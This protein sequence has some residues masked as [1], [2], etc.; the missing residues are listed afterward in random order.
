VTAE[1]DGKLQSFRAKRGVIVATGGFALNRDMVAQHAP[2]YLGCDPVDVSANDGWGIRAGESVG[3]ALKR[4]GAADVTWTLYPPL[5]RK[6]GI[7]VNAQGQR[8]MPEDSY[9]G[10]IGDAIIR[11]QQGVAFLILDAAAR[12][13]TPP[14]MPEK[15]VAE[16]KPIAEVE[17]LLGI[18]QPALQQTLEIYNRYAAKGEDPFFH[19]AKDHLRPL[20]PPYTAVNASVGHSFMGFLTLGGLLTTP[21]GQVLDNEGASI[22]HLYAVGRASAGIPSPYY[23]SS[24]LSLGECITFGRIAGRNAANSK[25]A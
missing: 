23:Y 20:V 11:E 7:L 18:A 3:G 22:P 17:H 15:V 8:F 9:F 6:Q 14:M 2:I 10:R 25:G 19:K 4:M 1:V 12:G 21:T 16:G 13:T 5:S 24:G